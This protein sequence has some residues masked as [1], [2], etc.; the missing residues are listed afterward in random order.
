MFDRQIRHKCDNPAT[1]EGLCRELMKAEKRL[2]TLRIQLEFG[3]NPLLYGLW[4]MIM[5]NFTQISPMRL[6]HPLLQSL[7][8]SQ[9]S[10]G[11]MHG[12]WMWVAAKDATRCSSGGSGT[13]LSALTCLSTECAICWPPQ[14]TK[15][16]LSRVTSP[17]SRPIHQ[18]GCLTWCLLTEHC[19]C[20]QRQ[21]SATS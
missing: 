6:V 11:K 18:A 7:H 5:T 13:V 21:L 2:C 17:T 14:K 20:C 9:H 1:I 12:F 19:T 4:P 8:F 3:S 15:T 16:S 10:I